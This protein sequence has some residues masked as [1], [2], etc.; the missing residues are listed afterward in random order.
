MFDLDKW[1]EIFLSLNRHKLRTILTAFGVFWGIFMLV[2]LLGA[3]NGLFNSVEHDF[4][5]EAI[6]SIWLT[7]RRTTMPY[8]GLKKGRQIKFDNSDYNFI[9][10]H[11]E[12]IDEITGRFFLSGDKKVTY[13]DKSLSFPVQSIHPAFRKIENLGIL[14]GRFLTKQDLDEVRKV[15]VIGT[16]AKENL[17]G[18]E[19]PLGEMIT[20]DNVVYKVIGVFTDSSDWILKNIY[21][22]ITTAQKVYSGQNRL[23]RIMFTTQGT[24][25]EEISKIEEQVLS[26]FAARKNFDPADKRAIWS[27][28]NA[29]DFEEFAGMMTAIKGI[30]WLVGIFTIIAGVIGVS[31]IMLIIVK[32]RTKEIG[33]RKSLGA[34]PFS[35]VSMILQ[36]SIFITALAGYAGMA[37]GVLLIS[38]CK[39]IKTDFW[40]TPHV[41]LSVILMATFVLVISGALAG[42]IPALKAA[43]VNPVIAMKSD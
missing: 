20:I 21:I 42:L 11:F 35:I 12:G 3:G 9:Q 2:L 1:Q 43:R 29:E 31:N 15:C 16:K 38:L 37:S 27:S 36:E 17:F 39:N 22:P 7:P 34:T 14:E 13:K 19:N 5:D 33:I 41:D 30:I 28:N 32:D 23:H 25:V 6:N 8:Q 24:D 18:D 40:R 26:A 10:E 4:A